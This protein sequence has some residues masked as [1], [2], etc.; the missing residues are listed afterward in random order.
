MHCFLDDL[1]NFR[2][3][4][5][6]AV[7]MFTRMVVAVRVFVGMI[8][9]L[10]LPE[11]FARQIFLAIGVYIHFSRRNS[12]THDR[13]YLQPCTDVERLDCVLQKL[14]RHSGIY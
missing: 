5:T 2:Q 14:W 9:L 11:N 7:A 3:G 13:R 6:V 1:A 10:L 8:V 4:A 12:G